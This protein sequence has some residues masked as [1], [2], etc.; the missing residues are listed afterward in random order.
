MVESRPVEPELVK[1]FANRI[2]QRTALGI[3][4]YGEPLR[5]HNGRSAK[6]DKTEE[7]LDALQYQYQELMET[8]DE[9]DTL[10]AFVQKLAYIPCDTDETTMLDWIEREAR[11]LIDKVGG[12]DEH[13]EGD[14]GS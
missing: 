6:R 12:A 5:T 7:L 8:Q 9:R 14:A 4:K 13:G 1:W 11:E 2:A 3:E 10:L